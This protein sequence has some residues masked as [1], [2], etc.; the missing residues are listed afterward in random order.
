MVHTTLERLRRQA[1][2]H[3]RR[4]VELRRQGDHEGA[5]AAQAL[6]RRCEAAANDI[7]ADIRAQRQRRRR[8]GPYPRTY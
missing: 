5:E 2:E 6:G 7:V 1:R 8:R 3:F 4:C